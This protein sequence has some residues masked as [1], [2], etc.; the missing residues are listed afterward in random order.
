MRELMGLL[1]DPQLDIRVV[2]ITGTNGKGTVAAAVS[3]L[4]AAHGLTVGT[5]T[6]PH[7][8]VI[9]ERISRNGELISDEELAEAIAGVAAVEQLMHSTPTWFEAITAAALRWFAEAPVDVAVIEVG[10]LGRYDATNVVDADVA[11]ITSIGGDHTDFAPGWEQAVAG[12]KAGIIGAGSIAVLGPMD[13][14]L[15][16]VFEAEGPAAVERFGVDFD[17]VQDAVAVGGHLADFRGLFANYGEVFVPLHGAHQVVNVSLAIAAT[18]AL[19][20]RE[21]PLDAVAEA[22]AQLADR[23]KGRIEVVAH[24]PLVVLDGSHNPDAI[25]ALVETVDSEF[26]P[27]GSRIVVFGQLQG[28]DPGA[29]LV[30]IAALRPDLVLC[31]TVDG[32]RGTPAA[33]LARVCDAQG[34]PNEVVVD[35]EAAVRRALAVAAEEDLVIVAGSFR[36]V[37]PARRA[38]L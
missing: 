30:E 33:E 19:F 1:G 20:G 14:E 12:E 31:T 13:D 25:A 18:E 15:V 9:N 6:S 38:V 36:L 21:L 32:S 22:V 29:A 23:A 2:H 8:S 24:F 5:F 35:P 4:I 27:V 7:H 17:V 37:D 10:L 34:L 28:R 26:S 3:A 11:V 16:A